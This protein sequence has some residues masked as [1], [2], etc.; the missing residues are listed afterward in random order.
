MV[1]NARI[2]F[3]TLISTA[4]KT[5]DIASPYFLPDAGLRDELVKAAKN[6]GV[7]VRILTV[8]PTTDHKVVR[9]SSRSS[10]GELLKAGAHVYEYQP[11]MIHE[12]LL[13]IDGA[14][15][16][17]GSTNMDTRSFGLNDEINVAALDR[18][19]AAN[20]TAQY[21]KDLG[22]ARPITLREW[23]RR[24]IFERAEALLGWLWVR[25]Q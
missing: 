10:Y 9:A 7:H 5:I 20:V 6:R 21:E 8:G 19:L 25:Q 14:W 18:N 12:K 23:Q 4:Q 11:G 1:S 2:L 24:G 22:D 15:V 3:Q 13:V 17:V 16:V